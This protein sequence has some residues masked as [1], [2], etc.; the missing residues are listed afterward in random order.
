MYDIIARSWIS[1]PYKLHFLYDHQKIMPYRFTYR[2]SF[3]ICVADSGN[4]VVICNTCESCCKP[5]PEALN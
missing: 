2:C 4:E 1:S 5:Q 3:D